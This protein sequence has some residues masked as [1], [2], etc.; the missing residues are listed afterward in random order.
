LIIKFNIVMPPN[1]WINSNSILQL[2]NYLPPQEISV[3]EEVDIID[4]LQDRHD[5]DDEDQDGYGEQ[6]GI[7]CAQN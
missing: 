6:P 3:G 5:E 7:S 1:N 2:K 4:V